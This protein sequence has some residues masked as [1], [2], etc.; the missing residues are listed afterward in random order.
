MF[1]V[2]ADDPLMLRQTISNN[3]VFEEFAPT[4]KNEQSY[5]KHYTIVL[6]VQGRNEHDQ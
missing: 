3:G 4:A 5:G 1:R 6:K 2:E